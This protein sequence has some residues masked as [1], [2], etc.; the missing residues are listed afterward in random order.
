MT[1]ISIQ[2]CKGVLDL[3]VLYLSLQLSNLRYSSI[4]PEQM[5]NKGEN[6]AW[7]LRSLLALRIRHPYVSRLG[8][9]FNDQIQAAKIF[10]SEEAVKVTYYEKSS[11]IATTIEV[12]R[13]QKLTF[14]LDSRYLGEGCDA[15]DASD[16]PKLPQ[17]QSSL[18][19]NHQWILQLGWHICIQV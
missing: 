12:V 7:S 1:N 13:V 5:W 11:M 15:L 17:H 10:Q 6:G 16:L 9:G 3:T 8:L 19:N 14:L 2:L 18:L 4:F